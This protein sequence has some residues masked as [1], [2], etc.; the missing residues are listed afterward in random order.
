MRRPL[1]KIAW[2]FRYKQLQSLLPQSWLWVTLP[3][4]EFGKLHT[5]CF[6]LHTVYL[7]VHPTET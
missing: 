4:H 3:H 1:P 5:I 2:H 6:I 7:E